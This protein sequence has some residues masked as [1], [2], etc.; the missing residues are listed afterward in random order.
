MGE[1]QLGFEDFLARLLLVKTLR[2]GWGF[3][4]VLENLPRIRRQLLKSGETAS[5]VIG[6]FDI[7]VLD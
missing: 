3:G 4:Q 1:D 5:Q 6:T 7:A 2:F